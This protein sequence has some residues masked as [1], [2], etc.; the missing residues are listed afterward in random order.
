MGHADLGGDVDIQLT[1][2]II[3]GQPL[4]RTVDDDAGVVD[5]PVEFR[6]ELRGECVQGRPVGD[7]EPG[8]MHAGHGAEFG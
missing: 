3:E 4:H 2:Q 7:V 1:G 8:R 6:R 5:H